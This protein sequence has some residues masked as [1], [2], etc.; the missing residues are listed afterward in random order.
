MA[1]VHDLDSGVIADEGI[2]YLLI[3]AD[4]LMGI[5]H[6]MPGVDPAMFLTA[7]GESVFRHVQKSFSVYASDGRFDGANFLARTCEVAATLGWG[8]WVANQHPDGS[9]TIEVRNSP[10]ASGFG[11]SPL[12]VCVPIVGVLRALSILIHG[13]EL[14]VIETNCAAQGAGTC[15]FRF[16]VP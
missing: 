12:P 7:L 9:R 16:G 13:S 2:R 11:P 5:A 8:S 10:F 1:L 4:V 6:H 15:K 3:R 14:P